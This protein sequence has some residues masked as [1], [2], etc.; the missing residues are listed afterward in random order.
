MKK[1]ILLLTATMVLINLVVKGQAIISSFTGTQNGNSIVL[2]WTSTS[3]INMDYY[4][5]EKSCIGCS[6]LKFVGIINA[7]GNSS[8]TLNYS[9]IESI[10]ATDT[11]FIYR[12][13]GTDLN[14][15]WSFY[16]SPI[17]VCA[18]FSGTDVQDL[19][20]INSISIYP[21]PSNGLFVIKWDKGQGTMGEL[22]I[23]NMLGEVIYQSL[24]QSEIYLSNQPSGIYFVQVQV[25]ERAYNKK[26]VVQ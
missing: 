25:G 5:I 8:T 13:E 9:F 6:A 1:T 22:E 26:L 15:Q 4:T 14:G 10:P 2:N 23:Y 24:L 3:E 7:A 19:S 18:S 20:E 16:L 21:N 12:L 17:T 11:C